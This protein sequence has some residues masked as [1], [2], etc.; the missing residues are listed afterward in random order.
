MTQSSTSALPDDLPAATE[1]ED[2]VKAITTKLYL[3]QL[4]TDPNFDGLPS[5]VRADKS[6]SVS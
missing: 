2:S 1:V 3:Q 5:G 6:V 4:D